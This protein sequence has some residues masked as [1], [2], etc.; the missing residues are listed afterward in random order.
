[1]RDRVIKRVIDARGGQGRIIIHL[2]CQ[3]TASVIVEEAVL[4]PLVVEALGLTGQARTLTKWPCEY[5][6]YEA[7]E[8]SAN[9]LWREAG[10]P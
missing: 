5:C 8:K 1:M 7:E 6:P 2:D 4:T 9:Q 3:H 10:E